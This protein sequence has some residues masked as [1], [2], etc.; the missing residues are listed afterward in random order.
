M[1]VLIIEDEIPARQILIKLIGKYFPDF[2]IAGT[3]D[4]VHAAG[5]WL[6]DNPSPD[7]IF[8]DV[9]LSDGKCFG[10]FDKA[11]ITCPVIVTTAYE[12][13]ALDAF[14]AK[15]IDYLMK[16]IEP[17]AFRMS[18]ERCLQ[19]FRSGESTPSVDIK[20]YTKVSY[21]HHFTIR[22]GSQI[23]I[24]DVNDIA[25][26]YSNDKSTYIVTRDGR[27]HMTDEPLVSIENEVDPIRFYKLSRKCIVSMQSIYTISKYFNSRLKVTVSP[28]NIEP[29]I[30]PRERV[31]SFLEWLEGA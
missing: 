31:Q 23:I 21:K 20:R 10:L 8:M 14:K 29:V 7:L 18:V 17:E 2:Q 13:Y 22:I 26:F 30:V 12:Q 19:L 16:P 24:L 4:S 6:A 1:K 27:E 5:K 15:C 3:L 25:Y 28:G 11:D 9:E